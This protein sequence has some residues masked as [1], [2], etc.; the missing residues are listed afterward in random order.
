DGLLQPH[1]PRRLPEVAEGRA[2]DSEPPV[3]AVV[4]TRDL[5]E[6]VHQ[7]EEVRDAASGHHIMVTSA[8]DTRLSAEPR[9]RSWIRSWDCS[10]SRPWSSSPSSQDAATSSVS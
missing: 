9:L 5:G 6:L 8:A 7:L 1:R 4:R 2:A 3:A 10:S